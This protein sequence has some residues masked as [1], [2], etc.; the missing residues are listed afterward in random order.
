[1]TS[2]IP[3]LAPDGFYC[4]VFRHP[5]NATPFQPSLTVI[6]PAPLHAIV[7]HNQQNA[8][9]PDLQA[10]A[11]FNYIERVA[12][13]FCCE[14]RVRHFVAELVQGTRGAH[15]RCKRIVQLA[16]R[17]G[18]SCY[19]H[20]VALE[21]GET[22]SA[23]LARHGAPTEYVEAVARVE[24]AGAVLEAA[25]ASLFA[26]YRRDFKDSHTSS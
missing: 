3:L 7:C 1:M 5:L 14:S 11:P 4:A 9:A 24:Q 26:N 16:A 20:D 6:T 15:S 23:Y 2:Y 18:V 22:N 8:E 21:G 25:A 17:Y 10:T 19:G 13:P 12:G